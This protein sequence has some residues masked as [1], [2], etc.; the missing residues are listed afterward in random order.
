MEVAKSRTI[1]STLI[2]IEVLISTP[3]YASFDNIEC[4]PEPFASAAHDHTFSP[5]PP[6]WN[7]ENPTYSYPYAQPGLPK[8][9]ESLPSNCDVAEV[10]SKT[11]FLV[12]LGAANTP[13]F[14]RCLE[15][16]GVFILIFES[17]ASR[18]AQ[19]ASEV[20]PGR[21][22]NRALILLGE[23]DELTPPL[24]DILPPNLFNL[25][26]PIFYTLPGNAESHQ[27][28]KTIEA[29]E[30]LFYRYRIYGT[31]SQSNACNLPMRPI[32]KEL[33]YDQQFHFYSNIR[34]YL[35]WPSIQALRKAFLGET[36]V[37]VAAGPDLPI[38]LH[39][40]REVRDSAVI[41]AVNNALKP[42]LDSGIRPHFAVI[43]DTSAQ[44]AKSW[45]G[46]PTLKD[47]SLVAH[48]LTNMGGTV[49]A[50]KFI[51]GNHKPEIFGNRPELRLHGSVIS[52]AFSLAR[53]MGCAQCVFVGAQLSSPDPWTMS[54]SKGS[55]H[56]NRATYP[57]RP[58][59]GRWP[60]LVPVK[61]MAGT[62]CYTTLNF[63]DAAYW[64]RDEVRA[65]QIPCVNISSAT[66][67]HGPGISLHPG[68][69]IRPTGRL[70]QRL[71]RIA[72]AR[73]TRP[74]MEP[75]GQFVKHELLHWMNIENEVAS[76]LQSRGDDFLMRA[77]KTLE[78]YDANN[79]TYLVQRFDNFNYKHFHADV[80]ESKSRDVIARGFFSY[81]TKILQMAKIMRSALASN[82]Q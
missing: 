10:L 14:R 63:L 22:V 28:Q 12:F 5:H 18:V 39:Y 11:R 32:R 1:L 42:L 15:E 74:A 62:T 37:L 54:Y 73:N 41:I 13:T 4:A 59:T 72:S 78:K 38:H 31:T 6:L 9:F 46:L 7:Y 69:P 17:D 53:Q 56:E 75:V 58:L 16:P 77:G 81:Y 68:Y 36:A 66:I 35:R 67:L 27:S 60:Q 64:L 24:S 50:R 23:P 33:F 49:F 51:F 19:F 8:V 43:N 76:I 80:F 57:E 82:F 30:I 26:F 48:C 25:G 71:Q 40:L 70:P 2:E 34:E 55:I 47:V 44:T 29:I 3:Q 20:R 52:T 79:V 45:D 65:S 21:L 61:D